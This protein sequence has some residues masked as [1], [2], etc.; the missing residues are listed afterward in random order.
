MQPMIK[1]KG[2][3]RMRVMK[4]VNPKRTVPD[5]QMLLRPRFKMYQLQLQIITNMDETVIV[6]RLEKV[7]NKS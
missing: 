7:Q 2:S 5:W 4:K 3:K 1:M 6:Q